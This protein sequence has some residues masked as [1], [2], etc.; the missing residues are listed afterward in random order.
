LLAL[1]IN[2]ARR[3]DR[4][5]EIQRQLPTMPDLVTERIEAEDGQ[6]TSGLGNFP[7]TTSTEHACWRSHAKAVARASV[8]LD[9]VLILED[10]AQFA[11]YAKWDALLPALSEVMRARKI[12][13]LQIGFI[14]S[15]YGLRHYEKYLEWLQ[16]FMRRRLFML[17][18]ENGR[19]PLVMLGSFRAGAHAYL[20]SPN[21][22]RLLMRQNEPPI[23]AADDLLT[24]LALSGRG[25]QGLLIARTTASWINQESRVKRGL[26]ID[27]DI[28]I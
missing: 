25:R 18:V 24:Y 14:K 27:S 28:Q 20:I 1:V 21:A 8:E 6:M 9:P 3:P 22:A 12:D 10:D 4:W 19:G 11:D 5:T 15:A 7:F 13:V 17:K 23:F 16:A 2:L 26:K